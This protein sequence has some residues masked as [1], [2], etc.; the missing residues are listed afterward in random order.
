[1]ESLAN[2][3]PTEEAISPLRIG[4]VNTLVSQFMGTLILADKD[5]FGIFSEDKI[6]FSKDYWAQ[7][8]KAY[9][10]TLGNIMLSSLF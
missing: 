7:I 4:T 8:L 9:P 2:I 10:A 3:L 1:M 5:A 6:S